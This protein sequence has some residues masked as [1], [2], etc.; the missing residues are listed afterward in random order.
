[1]GPWA[2]VITGS[3][4][5]QCSWSLSANTFSFPSRDSRFWRLVLLSKWVTG[6][7]DY[8]ITIDEVQ[9]ASEDLRSC[10]T[11]SPAV[12]AQCTTFSLSSQSGGCT[13]S[14]G[15]GFDFINTKDLSLDCCR[16]V[17]ESCREVVGL[18]WHSSGALRWCMLLGS[19]GPPACSGT[20]GSWS[21]PAVAPNYECYLPLSTAAC[22]AAGTNDCAPTA[23]PTTAPITRATAAPTSAPAG[24]CGVNGR[25]S[26]AFQCAS[27]A[28]GCGSVEVSLWGTG[29]AGVSIPFGELG[30]NL[31]DGDP[32]SALWFRYTNTVEYATIKSM[33]GAVRVVGVW[34][35]LQGD[36][37]DVRHT[38][39]QVKLG[40]DDVLCGTLTGNTVSGDENVVCQTPV[41]TDTVTLVLPDSTYIRG[42]ELVVCSAD[43]PTAAPS[44]S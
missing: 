13:N 31:V 10:P 18:Q 32:D 40:T 11:A 22:P 7:G 24:V 42:Y 21:S 30:T 8:A 20:W 15:Q 29:G 12:A 5:Q 41:I 28:S 19:G 14:L 2:T 16:A 23:T 9:F 39:L 4:T 36:P 37:Y 25:A 44:Q 6:P 1:M 27:G 43:P 38:G 17:A 3:G 33:G 34:I 35:K 26:T